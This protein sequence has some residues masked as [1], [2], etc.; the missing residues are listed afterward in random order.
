MSGSC[1]WEARL[2]YRGTRV[3]EKSNAGHP[4][5]LLKN[6]VDDFSYIERTRGPT[7]SLKSALARPELVESCCI[8]V[9]FLDFSDGADS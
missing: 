2:G 9:W 3:G 5:S 6:S 4:K 8:F 7:V 1:S